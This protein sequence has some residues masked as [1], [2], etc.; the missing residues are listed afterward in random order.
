MTTQSVRGQGTSDVGLFGPG[1]ASWKISRER[2]LML[3]GPRA[4]L[5]QVAHPRVA[6]GVAEHSDFRERPFR[7]L[8]RTLTLTLDSVFGE[9][10][11][12]RAAM[13]QIN[14]A[15]A[16]VRGVGYSALDRDL[17]LWVLA[18]L[19]DSSVLA[20]ELFLGPLDAA[21]K[22]AYYAETRAATRLL[23]LPVEG[24]PPDFAAL[25]RYVREMIASGEVRV[26]EEG[27]AVGLA[28]LYPP[29]AQYVPRPVKDGAAFVTAGVLP[30]TLREQYGLPWSH[31]HDAAFRLFV[32]AVR[33]AV[34]L[35]PR[36]VRDVPQAREA[37]RRL[38]L[39][40]RSA[41]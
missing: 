4:L 41:S 15:H 30:S 16:A 37:E 40:R 29:A 23:A 2:V 6:Q 1:S 7:R 33:A 39:D 28:T 17:L 20:Y 13:R 5:M 25:Q 24:G 10:R 26:T 14:Q 19:V 38:R 36:A 21:E 32:A 11:R 3:T 27:R 8:A 9:T 22:D 18:T 35:L 12:A 31:R 34:P